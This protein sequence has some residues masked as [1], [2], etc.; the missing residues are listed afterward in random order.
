M[1]NLINHLKNKFGIREYV[2]KRDDLG[3]IT[4][5]I[6]DFESVL[7]YLKEFKAYDH[8][9]MI[10]TVDRLED[11]KFQLTYL[12]HNYDL[13]KD[14]GLRVFIDREKSEFINIDNLWASA[15]AYQREIKELYGIDFP[16]GERL[17]ESFV[18]E[19][20]DNIPPMRRD[21]DTKKYAEETFYP[22]EGRHTKDPKVIMEE[23]GY[24][25]EAKIK[26]KIAEQFD[27]LNMGN[28]DE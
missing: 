1:D 14:I 27:K 6:K 22:R 20:W 7:L 10:S 23:K 15:K 2:L 3:F 13:K 28:K 19:G 16:G 17:D 5:E 11:N 24:P 21:F 25:V 8:L 4:V 12:L 18:L 9:V 26:K